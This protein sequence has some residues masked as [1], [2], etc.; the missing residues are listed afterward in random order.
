M[1]AG[2]STGTMND[3]IG[4]R[5]LEDVEED[6]VAETQDTA[7]IAVGA[8]TV[9]EV[10]GLRVDVV[11]YSPVKV[12]PSDRITVENV[13]RCTRAT[14]VAACA[15]ELDSLVLPAI[16]PSTEDMSMAEA[17]RAMIDELRGFRT[18]HE[19][20]VYLVHDDMKVIDALTRIIETVR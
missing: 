19:F 4:E 3:A 13:R 9:I 7:P 1:Y 2:T 18:D 5:M 10:G 20:T 6:L 12:D 16:Y 15:R 14:L 17:A 11:I 8:A